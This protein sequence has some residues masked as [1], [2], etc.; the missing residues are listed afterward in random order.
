VYNA[1]IMELTQK[2]ID[3]QRIKN[4]LDSLKMTVGTSSVKV[5]P[6]LKGAIEDFDKWLKAT[7]Q[8]VQ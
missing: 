8:N 1:P 2:Q 3:A 4:H 5:P 7:F 6:R